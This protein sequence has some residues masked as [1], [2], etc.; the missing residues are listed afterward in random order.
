[1]ACIRSKQCIHPSCK[2]YKGDGAPRSK[3]IVVVTTFVRTTAGATG[4]NQQK[5]HDMVLPSLLSLLDPSCIRCVTLAR[6]PAR[7]L[8]KPQTTKPQPC[9]TALALY[10][11]A[12][13]HTFCSYDCLHEWVAKEEIP[14]SHVGVIQGVHGMECNCC[15]RSLSINRVVGT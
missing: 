13:R 9:G 15:S 3:L 1:M 2:S 8:T 5:E 6:P 4:K 10:A 14:S 12:Q 11:E 7:V